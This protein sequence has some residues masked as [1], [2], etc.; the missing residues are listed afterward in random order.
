MAQKKGNRKKYTITAIIYDKRGKILAT[1]INS[2]T[3]THPYQYR[4]A[5]QAGREDAIYLH[6]EIQ[7]ILKTKNIDKAHRIFIKRLGANGESLPACPC[8]ICSIAIEEAGIKIVE[9]T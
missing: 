7:A 1:G 2:Y 5:K 6:A 4:L 3:K 8:E 9:H